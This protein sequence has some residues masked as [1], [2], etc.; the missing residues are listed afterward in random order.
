MLKNENLFNLYQ[1][2]PCGCGELGSAAAA[3]ASVIKSLTLITAVAAQ[4]ARLLLKISFAGRGLVFT[5]NFFTKIIL[6]K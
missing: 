4:T 1:T 3:A 5:E 6:D 2:P